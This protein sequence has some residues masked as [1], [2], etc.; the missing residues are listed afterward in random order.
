ML[1][2]IERTNHEVGRWLRAIW[3]LHASG[4]FDDPGYRA[5]LDD[6]SEDVRAWAVRLLVDRGTPLPALLDHFAELGRGDP[7]PK[8]RL[9]LASALNRLPLA[10]RWALAEALAGHKEDAGD[11][12]LPL[13]VWYGAEPLVAA[14]LKRAAAWAGRCTIPLLRQ[15]VARRAVAA[16]AAAGLAAIIAV[17]Q[18]AES[19]ACADLLIGTHEALGAQAHRRARGMERRFQAARGGE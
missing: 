6:R 14:D 9:S 12:M 18:N 16:D 19:A 4:G 17:L 11:R 8:V 15:N 10:S 7:S 5:L 2:E 13:M 1:R 3:A